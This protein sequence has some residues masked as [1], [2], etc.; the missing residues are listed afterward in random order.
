MNRLL[1]PLLLLALPA[2][3]RAQKD[4]TTVLRKNE[5]VHSEIQK[6]ALTQ[7]QQQW[8]YSNYRKLGGMS[9]QN[10][11][12]FIRQNFANMSEASLDFM[13]SL[14]GRLMQAD[15][16]EQLEQMKSMLAQ[17]KSQKKSIQEKIIKKEA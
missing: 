14:A 16:S 15:Q 11:T 17:L 10:A 1:I 2:S 7:Q 9:K 8:L 6:S 3:L 4:T 13:I 12:G 5:I